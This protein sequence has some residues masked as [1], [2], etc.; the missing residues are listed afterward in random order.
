MIATA[1]LKGGFVIVMALYIK[2]KILLKFIKMIRGF[3]ILSILV[4]GTIYS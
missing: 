4:C 2:L 1:L 3:N